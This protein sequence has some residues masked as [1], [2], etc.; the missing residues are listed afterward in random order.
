[1]VT[2]V[3]CSHPGDRVSSL[4]PSRSHAS[5]LRSASGSVRRQP[6]R[7]VIRRLLPGPPPLYH[8][9]GAGSSYWCDHLLL[10]P[11]RRVRIRRRSL[12]S[13]PVFLSTNLSY[14]RWVSILEAS[15][16]LQP[17]WSSHR[18]TFMC[19]LSEIH[20]RDTRGV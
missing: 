1:M 3:G 13:Q 16:T 20:S 2:D 4:L 17:L 9:V 8:Q 10:C 19:V 18:R 11:G 7:S 15:W 6:R 5:S 12:R 14:T